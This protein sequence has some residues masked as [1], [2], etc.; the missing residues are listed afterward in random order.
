MT[1]APVPAGADAVVMVEYTSRRGEQVKI[2]RAV[3]AGENVVPRGSEARR[4]DVLLPRGMR[5]TPAA[6][7]AAAAAGKAEVRVHPRPRVAILSTG[8]ELVE[9]AAEPGEN[10][11]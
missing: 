3:A 6:I 2:E 5:M 8:D 7:A 11:I 9:I 1:G 4:G 10:Q